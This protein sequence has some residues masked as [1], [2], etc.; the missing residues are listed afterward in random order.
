MLSYLQGAYT[1][2]SARK[3]EVARLEHEEL[4]H[5]A[6]Q[7]VNAEEHVSRVP[8]LHGVSVN[9][10]SEA[11]VLHVGKALHGD[12]VAQYGRT[13]ESLAQLPG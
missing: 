13:V 7:F 9:V 1:Y 2:R 10:E 8:L 5:V 3:D 11:Y 12:E 4:A 6:Y